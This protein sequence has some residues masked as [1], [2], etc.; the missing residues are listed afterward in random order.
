[1]P[2]GREQRE[3]PTT[4]TWAWSDEDPGDLAHLPMRTHDLRASGDSALGGG[5]GDAEDFHRR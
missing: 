2:G 1:L 5:H 4:P 3:A